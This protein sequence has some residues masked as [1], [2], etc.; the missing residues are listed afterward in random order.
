MYVILKK[1]EGLILEYQQEFE[2][3]KRERNIVDFSDVEHFALQILCTQNE[4]GEIEK[5]QIA[6]SY[7]EKFEEIAIDEYQDSNLVQEYILKSIARENNIFMVGDVKQSI[8][9]FRQ[10]MPEL[11]LSKYASYP[12]KLE[13]NGEENLKIQLFKNFRSRENVLDITNLVFKNIMSD[14]LGDIDYNEDEYLN[15]GADYEKNS[16]DLKTEVDIIDLAQQEDEEDIGRNEDEENQEKSAEPEE[17]I[18]DIEIEARFVAKRIQQLIQ[19]KFQVWD[20]KKG[21]FRDIQYKDI[22]V[23]L[24]ATTQSAPIFEQE[25]LKLEMPVFADSSQGYLDSI[26]IQTVMSLLKII[27]NPMQD[28]PLVTVLRSSIGGFSDNDLVEIRLNDKQ[29]NFY[30]CLKKAKVN[31]DSELKL[32]IE[33]FLSQLEVWRKEQE[34]LSLDELIWKIYSDTGYYNYVGLMPN[35][36][37]RQANLKMLFERAKSYEKASFKGLYH[38]IHFIERLQLSSGDMGVAKIIGENEN[39]IRIMSIHKSK[40]LEFPVV[41]LAQTGK[42]FNLMDLN[43]SILLHQDLGIGVKYKDDELQVQYDTLTKEAIKNKMKVE[44]LSEEMR[45]L[46]VALTRAKEKLIITGRIKEYEKALTKMQEQVNQYPSENGK[47]EHILVKK[48]KKYLDWLM[49]VY[50]Y[51]QE[52]INQILNWNV[53]SKKDVLAENRELPQKENKDII[54]EFE[55][56]NID[57]ST[58][59]Q[60]ELQEILNW[61]YPNLL[62]TTIP[63][64]ASV[65]QLKQLNQEYKKVEDLEISFPKP[66]FLKSQDDKLTNAQKGTLVHLCMQY[67]RENVSYDLKKVKDLIQDLLRREIITEKEA[68][69]INPYSILQFTKSA[70]WEE[71]QQAKEIQREKA[72]YI[73]IPAK[74]IYQKELTENIL[75]QGIIDLY[76]INKNGELIL[77]DYKTDYVEKGNEKEIV[78]KYRKQLDLY[79]QALEEALNRKVEK[80]YIYSTYL[81]KE[82]EIY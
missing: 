10:A 22:V 53:Y 64:K 15:L 3:K 34:I 5:T 49:L 27:D 45:I 58:G 21:S 17:R 18:E 12:S 46:Y 82:I 71:L 38:F 75:V 26:E 61:E 31:A 19:E 43:E 72:F 47:I 36:E 50:L 67:L 62:A 2:K 35:G 70:I 8:Y 40:G 42:Q 25:I 23:L 28:I 4:N 78:I 20:R 51:E 1:L 54:Q 76:Y 55:E 44:T 60:Q 39:V 13:Q 80:S 11:F 56:N 24:R 77:V 79:K 14:L 73:Q 29:D 65:T 37:L 32:K 66:K 69:N 33:K 57:I 52:N 41:I 6:K 74:E 30:I 63:T 7:E 68:E 81:G 9:K 16:Q 48:Y 59:I